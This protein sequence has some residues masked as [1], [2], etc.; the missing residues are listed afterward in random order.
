VVRPRPTLRGVYDRAGNLIRTT[1]FNGQTIDHEY[2]NDNRLIA[3]LSDAVP[4]SSLTPQTAAAKA[5]A[6]ARH[7]PLCLQRPRPTCRAYPDGT[8]IAYTY[9][10]AGNIQTITTPAGVATYAYDTANRLESV[11]GPDGGVTVYD[12]DEAGNLVRTELPNGVVELRQYDERNRLTS[13]TNVGPGANV[14]SQHHYFGLVGHRLAI[15]EQGGRRVEYTYD[16]LHHLVQEVVID[17]AGVDRRISFTYDVVG[18]RLSQDDSGAGLTTFVY[19]DNDRL[20]TETTNGAITEYM[21]DANGSV[22]TREGPNGRTVYQWDLDNRLVDA[23]TDGDGTLDLAYQYDVDGIR[24]GVDSA[25]GQ[26][27]FLVDSN[28]PLPVVLEEYT[29]SGAHHGVMRF[30]S[31][32]DHAEPR[33]A[34]IVYLY[35]GHS[36]VRA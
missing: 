22:L 8:S 1:D 3:R 29:P 2:D 17:P 25:A 7:D 12:Y 19:D 20:L 32:P 24:V 15:D 11:T 34:D 4:I 13:V 36:G 5:S 6:T 18:N 21:Y 10:D 27:R 26:T 28:R 30:R 23:D 33:R 14:L 31:G 35:D 16:N 9:D